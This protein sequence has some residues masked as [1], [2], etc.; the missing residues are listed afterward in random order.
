MLWNS[1][2][3]IQRKASK[4]GEQKQ[5][6]ISKIILAFCH[7]LRRGLSFLRNTCGLRRRPDRPGQRTN[8]SYDFVLRTAAALAAL[9]HTGHVVNYT[10]GDSLDCCLAAIQMTRIASVLLT[11]SWGK[12]VDKITAHVKALVCRSVQASLIYCNTCTHSGGDANFLD[13]HAF[14]L[15]RFCFFQRNQQ[16]FRFSFSLSASKSTLPMVVWM[17]P[18]CR[19]GN[20]PGLLSRF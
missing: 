6:R 15:S 17:M 16:S 7:R 19:Y 11:E 8:S 18:F 2:H 5:A 3:S 1:L 9:V 4:Y 10:P 20:E 12:I 13:V 14:R